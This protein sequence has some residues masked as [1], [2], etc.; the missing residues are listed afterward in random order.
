[1]RVRSGVVVVVDGRVA[2]IRRMRHNRTYYVFPGGGVEPGETPEA[3]AVREAHEEL[4]LHLRLNRL[5]ATVEFTGNR[6]YYYLATITGG[7]FGTGTGPE[8]HSPAY[9]GRGSYMPVWLRLA[10]LPSHD[11]RP[12]GLAAVLSGRAFNADGQPITIEE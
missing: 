6:Q 10:D 3:A 9:S 4:G 12:P 8:F 1:M 2:L 11:V 5:V 7:E